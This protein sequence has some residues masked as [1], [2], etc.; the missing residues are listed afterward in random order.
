M[1][2]LFSD[3]LRRF[4]PL[5]VSSLVGLRVTLVSPAVRS[6]STLTVAGERTVEV[7]SPE[8]TSRK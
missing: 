6:L 1:I 3:M 5:D 8:R 7:L 2:N 4:N